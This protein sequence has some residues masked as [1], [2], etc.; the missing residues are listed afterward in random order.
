MAHRLTGMLEKYSRILVA[1]FSGLDYTETIRR[2]AERL[3]AA[4]VQKEGAFTGGL[5]APAFLYMPLPV[6]KYSAFVHFL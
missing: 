2:K 3:Y 1:N 6:H 5:T 4:N